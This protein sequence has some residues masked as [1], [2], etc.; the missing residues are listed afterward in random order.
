MR[1]IIELALCVCADTIQLV[2]Q[3]QQS[4]N[5]VWMQCN[6]NDKMTS[7]MNTLRSSLFHNIRRRICVFIN[8]R[9]MMRI[10]RIVCVWCSSAS[11]SAH[12]NVWCGR[13]V[14]IIWS[15]WGV[16]FTLWVVSNEHI[17]MQ[18]SVLERQIN[19]SICDRYLLNCVSKKVNRNK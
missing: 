10:V 6:C 17:Y 13:T 8:F 9:V 14:K 2:Q 4:P 1:N 19:H 3:Q 12:W 16:D 18:K 11:A 5:V 7:T 15:F